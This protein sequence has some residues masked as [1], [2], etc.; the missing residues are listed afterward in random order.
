[1]ANRSDITTH[2]NVL[3]TRLKRRLL[4]GSYACAVETLQLMRHI[5]S[6]GRWPTTQHLLNTIRDAGDKLTSAQPI[7]LAVGNVVR[8]VLRAVREEYSEYMRSSSLTGA[9]DT[10]LPPANAQIP[11]FMQSGSAEMA[12]ASMYN[13]LYSDKHS[14]KDFNNLPELQHVLKPLYIQAVTELM[15]EVDSIYVN[16]SNQSIDHIHSNE[17][18]MITGRSKTVEEFLKAAHRKRK[19]QVIVCETAPL[20]SGQDMAVS[21]SKHGIDTTLIPDSAI[22]AVMSRVNKVILG[23]HAVL[24][25]GG[26]I[27][28]SGTHMLTRAANYHHVPCVV[29][30]A[31][32]KLSPLQPYDEDTFNLCVSPDP[33]MRFED[34]IIGQVQ[35]LNPFFDYIAPDLINLF[36]T[37]AGGH[38]PSYIYRL[39]SENYDE[40]DYHLGTKSLKAQP[41]ST[42]SSMASSTMSLP[43]SC[44]LTIETSSMIK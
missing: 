3:A 22:Y 37:N 33:I 10:S 35:V 17:I 5:I 41:M 36:V 1:M 2:V 13:L 30:T 38:P 12:P 40:E 29:L 39:L 18:I 20:F 19:F 31:L 11:A 9:S 27:A 24:A 44:P 16:I 43:S 21:L 4:M 42:E 26:L 28:S 8:R 34:E 32:F 7:E 6:Y 15:D 25:N 23:C 14:R